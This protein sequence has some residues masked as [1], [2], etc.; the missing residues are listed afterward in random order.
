MNLGVLTPK[1]RLVFFFFSTALLCSPLCEDISVRISLECPNSPVLHSAF[2]LDAS[3]MVSCFT[4]VCYPS[5][6]CPLLHIL[7][8]LS[9]VIAECPPVAIAETLWQLL[10][11][12]CSFIL[13]LP[14]H[15]ILS[16]L[17]LTKNTKST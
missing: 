4:S 11:T 17:S 16:C 15:V 3:I 6:R 8:H 10:H 7:G 13:Y 14:V 9:L 2:Y 12:L 5:F 1:Y